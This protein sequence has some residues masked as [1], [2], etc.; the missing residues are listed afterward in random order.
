MRTPLAGFVVGVIATTLVA[1]TAAGSPA[2]GAGAPPAS[3]T[4]SPSQDG[5]ALDG[6]W[7]VHL[8]DPASSCI[9]MQ[10]R[11]LHVTGG[12]ATISPHVAG[13]EGGDP[14]LQGPATLEGDAVVVHVENSAPTKDYVDFSGTLGTDGTVAGTAEAG[15]IHPSLTNGYTCS[16]AATLAPVAAPTTT[17]CTVEAV[18]AALDTAPGRTRYVTLKN[19]TTQLVCAGQWALA[20]P[21]VELDSGTP[22][23]ESDLLQV[24]DGAW[25]VRDFAAE[26]ASRQAPEA[27]LFACP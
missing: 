15:G 3:S 11:L 19:P 10:D 17:E 12:T 21:Q 13:L 1:C 26:C 7:V 16:Y 9:V 4:P 22:T 20:F 25:E 18:Q 8:D 27:V 14:E 24:T 6:V 5:G 23:L 2:G